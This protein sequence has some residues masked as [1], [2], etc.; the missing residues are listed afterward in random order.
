MRSLVQVSPG[1][2]PRV[3][4]KCVCGWRRTVM[5][6][7]ADAA[8]DRH[9]ARPGSAADVEP[10]RDSAL[11]SLLLVD[12]AEGDDAAHSAIVGAIPEIVQLVRGA[13]ERV[14]PTVRDDLVYVGCPTCGNVRTVI[15]HGPEDMPFCLHHP[16]GTYVWRDAGSDAGWTQM[17][18]VAVR[19]A[20]A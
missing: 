12:I 13:E 2:P 1:P 16:D 5:M 18:P 6:G 19:W 14:Y 8:F 9:L 15:S 4:I 17:R 11:Y 20:D 7:D 3:E 10:D